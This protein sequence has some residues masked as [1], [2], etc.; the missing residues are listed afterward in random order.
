MRSRATLTA[1]AALL[2]IWIALAV[3]PAADAY[4]LVGY[5][6]SNPFK[7]ELQQVGKGTDFPDPDADPF[8]VEY[9][10]TEQNVTELGVVDFL[11]K[12]PARVAVAS[13]KCFYYQTDH[14]RGS[15]VQDDERTETY[16]FDGSYYFDLARGVG[17]TYARNFTLNNQTFDP[18]TVPGFPE[19]YKPFFGSGEGGI[20]FTDGIPID[21]RCVEKAEETDPY[22]D[23]PKGDPKLRLKLDYRKGKTG[24][25]RCTRSRVDA[26][27]KGRDA[28]ALERVDFLVSGKRVARDREP[29]FKERIARDRLKRRPTKITAEARLDDGRDARLSRKLRR[30]AKRR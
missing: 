5:D 4:D 22:V 9:D 8:C 17:G 19:E 1:P 25:K 7:C 18:T 30:C 15:I 16:N 24:G 29:P 6:G 14:W 3:G 11:S 21:Q 13:D 26:L 28:R 20:Q 10:K 2:G 12:E 23:D 27:V